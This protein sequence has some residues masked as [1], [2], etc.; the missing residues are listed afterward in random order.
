MTC[1]PNRAANLAANLRPSA[2]RRLPVLIGLL[3][4]V[5]TL[6]ALGGCASK[7]V[8]TDRV[9]LLPQADGRPSAVEVTA[10]GQKVL[11][12]KPYASVDL[13]GGTLRPGV[14]D[15]ATVQARYGSLLAQQPARPRSFVVS[16]ESGGNRLTSTAQPVLAEMRSALANLPAAEVVVIGHTDLSGSVE[17]NDKLSLTRAEAVRELLVAAGVARS[18]VT[19]VGRGKREPLVQATDEAANA[20]NRRVEIKIR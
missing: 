3:A 6:A 18:A 19:V 4:G 7:P 11:L 2:A 13:Q 16:F 1:Q 14:T 8:V 5:V 17:T 12:D 10:A 20:R 9:I 15:A